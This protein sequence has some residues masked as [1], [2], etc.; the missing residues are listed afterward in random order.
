MQPRADNDLLRNFTCRKSIESS[1]QKYG[2]NPKK[3]QHRSKKYRDPSWC[4]VYFEKSEQIPLEHAAEET[5]RF[6]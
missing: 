4:L 5:P 6:F 2:L 1:A 3:R